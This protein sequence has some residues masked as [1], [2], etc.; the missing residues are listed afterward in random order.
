MGIGL[1]GAV[2]LSGVGAGDVSAATKK[3]VAKK[4][5]RVVDVPIRAYKPINEAKKSVTKSGYTVSYDD[6]KYSVYGK[7]SSKVDT[8]KMITATVAYGSGY[9]KTYAVKMKV[10]KGIVKGTFNAKQAYGDQAVK[11]EVWNKSSNG[12]VYINSYGWYQF[13]IKDVNFAKKPSK[14]I[15]STDKGIVSLAKSVT[16]GKKTDLEKSRAIY[17]YVTTHVKYDVKQYKT[18]NAIFYS[19]VDTMKRKVAMCTG[20]A[21]LSAAMHR[22][23]GIEATVVYGYVNGGLHAWNEVH[24]GKSWYFQDPTFGAGYVDLNKGTFT[25]SYTDKYLNVAYPKSHKKTGTYNF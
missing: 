9:K 24:I 22:S 25:F 10:E 8:K 1:V 23:L 17:K 5:S 13:R 7:V 6:G 11:L 15:Q 2:L 20:Y 16:A 19:S 18:G 3:V 21:N 4:A 14:Y 12:V